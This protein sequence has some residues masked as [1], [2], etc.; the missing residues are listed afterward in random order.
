VALY[1]SEPVAEPRHFMPTDSTQANW[2]FSGLLTTEAGDQLAYF[3]QLERNG[4]QYHTTA[5]LFDVATQQVIFQDESRAENP[6]PDGYRW[7]IGHAMLRFNPINASWVFGVT[8]PDKQGF[9]FK[10]DLLDAEQPV[11]EENLRPGLSVLASQ[12]QALNGHVRLANMPQEQFVIAKHAWFKQTWVTSDQFQ[13]HAV[14]SVLCHLNDGSSIYSMRLPEA[15]ATT[16]AM[17]GWLNAAGLS[18]PVSQ[19][20]DVQQLAAGPWDIHVPSSSLHLILAQHTQHN[21]VIAGFSQ[22]KALGAFCLLGQDTFYLVNAD[23]HAYV[24]VV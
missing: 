3:F 13:R 16:G 20:I 8:T 7:S 2:L 22:D 9:N 12:A 14:D 18:M 6:Q 15:D 21:S 10:M 1:A 5:A 24:G 19:F 23:E 11:V 17:A 4:S